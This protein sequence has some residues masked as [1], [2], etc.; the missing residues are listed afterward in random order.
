MDERQQ[1]Y[2][3]LVIEK[4]KS[5]NL[6]AI[7]DRQDAQVRHTEDS[8][9][10]LSRFDWR[11]KSVIDVGAGGGFPGI[12]LAIACP[13]ARLTLL[14]A[15][16]KKV[17]FLA[18]AAR[19]LALTNVTALHGRAEELAQQPDY[20]EQYD[21][22]VS[23]GVARLAVLVELC[24]P[25]VKGGGTMGAM[26]QHDSERAD[27]RAITAALG[28]AWRDSVNYTLSNGLTHTLIVVE[29]VRPTPKKYPRRFAKIDGSV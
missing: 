17:A 27:A 3:D 14:D 24:L 2:L 11:G 23:R 22:C 13:E 29:K 18:E 10:L 15:T 8:L 5:M 20:R 21:V 4:N 1:Q 9:A 28:G 6:T 12:P 19:A 7:T 16:G 26:K 25:F